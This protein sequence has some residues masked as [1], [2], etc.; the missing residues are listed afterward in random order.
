VTT[1]FVFSGGGSL[2]ATQVGMLV[3]LAEHGVTPD[4]VVGASIGAINAAWVTGRPGLDG[5]RALADVWGGVQR[6]DVFP[7]SPLTGIG[8]FFGRRNHLVAPHALRRLVERHLEFR[9]LE[10]ASIP[11]GIVST[12]LNSGTETLLTNGSTIEAVIASA[13]IPGVF[14][15]VMIEG[16]PHVDGGVINNAP[17]SHAVQWGAT[18]VYVLPT[19]YSCALRQESK[20]ALGVAL[21][22]LN[23]LV[24]RRLGE[25]IALYQSRID[26]RVVPP[27]CP[28]SV[29]PVDFSHT[30]ELI[31]RAHSSCQAWLAL[32]APRPDDQSLAFQA[33]RHK[34]SGEY[35]AMTA[36]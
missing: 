25:D 34:G 10:D 23:L 3:A 32:G 35:R 33:H 20:S 21:Q 28:I 4:Y 27:L 19:G 24:Q 11:I 17:I 2:G 29:S 9:N 26:L 16:R 7:S 14:P 22:A 6:R 15:P 36:S 1:A 8:G 18:T 31:E 5:A 13:S 30:A 12:D